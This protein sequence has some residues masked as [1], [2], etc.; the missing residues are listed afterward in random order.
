VKNP[1]VNEYY[2]ILILTLVLPPFH[3]TADICQKPDLKKP[4]F[5][6]IPPGLLCSKEKEKKEIV[7]IGEKMPKY[8][9]DIEKKIRHPEFRKV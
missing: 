4:I 3:Y 2:L 5:I 7:F 6:Q 8:K 1:F 9:F